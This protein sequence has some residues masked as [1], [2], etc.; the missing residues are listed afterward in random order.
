MIQR[1]ARRLA[2]A[3]ER[4]ATPG[5]RGALATYRSVLVELDPGADGSAILAALPPVDGTAT[6]TGRERAWDVPVCLD[7]AGRGEP[8]EDA[9]EVAAALGIGTDEMNARLLEQPL[10]VGMYGFAPGFAY[11]TGL[12]G[13]LDVPRRTVPRPPVA[14]GSLMIAAGQAAI[15][16]A[17]TPTGWYVVG[18]TAARMFDPGRAERGEPPVPFLPGDTLHLVRIDADALDALHDDPA[19]GVRERDAR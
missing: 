2:D 7:G 8:A 19:G 13:R 11:L 6:E 5:L 3:L 15:A 4:A 16:P 10:T 1:R 12:D 14:P 18:R 9:A 17:P